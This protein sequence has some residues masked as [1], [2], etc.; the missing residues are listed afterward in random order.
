MTAKQSPSHGL[1]TV[2]PFPER[3]VHP[4]RFPLL[5]TLVVWFPSASTRPMAKS[6]DWSTLGLPRI[7]R[8]A[9]LRDNNPEEEKMRCCYPG[10]FKGFRPC[11]V[12]F[13]RAREGK[14]R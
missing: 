5:L 13:A 9:T 4:S 10:L 8:A 1:S 3:N 12:H 7:S 11:V 6:G 14:L 2:H